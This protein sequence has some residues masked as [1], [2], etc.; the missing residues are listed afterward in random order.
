MPGSP[1]GTSAAGSRKASAI[2]PYS[3]LT[4]VNPS[5]RPVGL[6]WASWVWNTR[7]GRRVGGGG[8]KPI[9][10][11]PAPPP[12][13]GPGS[14]TPSPPRPGSASSFSTRGGAFFRRPSPSGMSSEKRGHTQEI[15]RT[16]KGGQ[17]L[18]C[19]LR[20]PCPYRP[21]EIIQRTGW[22][23]FKIGSQ[24]RARQSPSQ[25]TGQREPGKNASYK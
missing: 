5:M 13:R 17:G 1:V 8:G 16:G 20:P 19:S 9:W 12:P 24:F 22:P 11:P 6:P 23:Q 10:G 18:G 7:R 15:C 14:P 25:M 3:S 4:L 2:L 21:N